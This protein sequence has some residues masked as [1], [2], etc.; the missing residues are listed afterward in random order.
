[1]RGRGGGLW[2]ANTSGTN[3]FQQ[4]SLISAFR[5]PL[6]FQIQL[7]YG[8]SP[9]NQWLLSRF[10]LDTARCL[11]NRVALNH[12]LLPTVCLGVYACLCVCVL[13]CVCVCLCL[14][15]CVCVYFCL[16][17]CVCVYVCVCVCMCVCVCAS[18]PPEKASSMR[19]ILGLLAEYL[20]PV[21]ACV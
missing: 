5:R 1:M 20:W 16:C 15:V 17:V 11:Q 8:S 18:S 9:P 10:A 21:C 4:N 3:R 2:L 7:S 12:P 13:V 6:H 19:C 14:Y